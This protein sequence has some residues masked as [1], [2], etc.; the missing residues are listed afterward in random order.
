MHTFAEDDSNDFKKLFSYI[1]EKE[2]SPDLK[3]FWEA[4]KK[5]FWIER[6]KRKQMASKVST[7][8]I[9]HIKSSPRARA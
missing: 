2:L 4:Q 6:F 9:S 5:I 3:V 7:Y 1:D 8:S